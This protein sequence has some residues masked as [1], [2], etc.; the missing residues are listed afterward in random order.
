MLRRAFIS[1]AVDAV[2]IATVFVTM[3]PDA[4]DTLRRCC[5]FATISLLIIISSDAPPTLFRFACSPFSPLA[6]DATIIA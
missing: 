5:H 3:P 6:D 1:R 2:A 4:D